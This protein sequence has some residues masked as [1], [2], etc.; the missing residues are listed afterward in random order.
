MKVLPA[1]E[2]EQTGISLSRREELG[3][4]DRVVASARSSYLY[5]IFLGSWQWIGERSSW[6]RFLSDVVSR[7]VCAKLRRLRSRQRPRECS[8][9]LSNRHLV[10]SLWSHGFSRDHYDMRTILLVDAATCF[11]IVYREGKLF[12]YLVATRAKRIVDDPR[13]LAAIDSRFPASLLYIVSPTISRS[14]TRNRRRSTNR[15]NGRRITL[16]YSLR[17]FRSAC[18]TFCT[19]FVSSVFLLH[20]IVQWA[21]GKLTKILLHF[22]SLVR[23]RSVEIRRIN[24]T[25]LEQFVTQRCYCLWDRVD[26]FR[27]FFIPL[28]RV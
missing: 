20:R 6:N 18:S 13:G 27:D 5:R 3:C 9:T 25:T 28:V 15:S 26:I 14:V 21:I 8:G 11:D 4:S 7:P 22:E 16:L 24:S 17:S 1:F 2:V 10:S 23:W 12:L 19:W